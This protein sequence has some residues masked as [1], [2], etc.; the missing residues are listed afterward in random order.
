MTVGDLI[1]FLKKFDPKTQVGIGL[2]QFEDKILFD[3]LYEEDIFERYVEL[4]D[5][6]GYLTIS[7]QDYDDKFLVIER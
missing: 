5:H 1:E 2:P 3:H 4:D 6:S 7:Q